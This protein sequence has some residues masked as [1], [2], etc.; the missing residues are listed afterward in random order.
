MT[1]VH[2]TTL[3]QEHGEDAGQEYPV[4]NPC[5]ADGSNRST[6]FADS[7]K[8]EDVSPQQAARAAGDIGQRGSMPARYDKRDSGS[9]NRRQ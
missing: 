2:S 9:E 6:E 7:I 5:A 4:R 1:V 8:I 3:G